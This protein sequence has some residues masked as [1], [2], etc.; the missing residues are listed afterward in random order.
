MKWDVHN[1]QMPMAVLTLI[2]TLNIAL[3]INFLIANTGASGFVLSGTQIYTLAGLELA[4]VIVAYVI[5]NRRNA[6]VS[7]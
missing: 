4:G 3:V 2:T 1:N 6:T 5:G 7:F